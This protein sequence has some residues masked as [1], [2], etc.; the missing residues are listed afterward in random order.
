MY[1]IVLHH[2]HLHNF[3]IIMAIYNYIGTYEI[4]L[5]YRLGHYTVTPP[6]SVVTRG[7]YKICYG[8]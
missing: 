3:V 1:R 7:K 8:L 6:L 5:I 2:L 4:M